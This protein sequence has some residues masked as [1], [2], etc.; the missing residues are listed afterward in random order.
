MINV[1]LTAN[2]KSK[3]KFLGDCAAFR[4]TPPPLHASMLRLC[5]QLRHASQKTDIGHEDAPAKA[6][7]AP[8]QQDEMLVELRQAPTRGHT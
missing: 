6:E 2:K 1:G 5:T 3:G 7:D 8:Q 4:S